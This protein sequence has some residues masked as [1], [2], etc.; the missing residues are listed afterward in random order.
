MRNEVVLSAVPKPKPASKPDQPEPEPSPKLQPKSFAFDRVFG[1]DSSQAEVF[2]QAEPIVDSVL[3]GYNG[4]IFVY[5]QTGTGKTHTM[6]GVF[7]VPELRGVCGRCF[8][9]IFET[10]GASDEDFGARPL[11]PTVLS[12]KLTAALPLSLAAVRVSYLDIYNEGIRDLLAKDRKAL[13]LKQSPEQGVYAQ[14]LSMFALKSVA[15]F[16]HVL[17]AG[18]KNR[19]VDTTKMGRTSAH[20]HSIFTIV[21]ESSATD[22]R[23]EKRVRVGKLHLV[24]LAGSEH[25]RT[26]ATIREA[27]TMGR[28]MSALRTV[29]S[30]LADR[31]QRPLPRL[32]D[33][34]RGKFIP[35]RDSKL[36]RLLQDSLGGSAKTLMIATIGPADYNYEETLSTL[37]FAT[38]AKLVHNT[39][40]VNMDPKD[41]CLRCANCLLPTQ[42]PFCA[43]PKYLSIGTQGHV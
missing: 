39:P 14:D 2:E 32:A 6:Q 5:G 38:L 18:L 4:T 15:E 20:A 7:D 8:D 29:V 36:T 3:R 34:G 26:T 23:G 24:E 22:A 27:S 10:I 1:P 21:V 41:S 28:S 31:R 17:N 25:P 9:R 30:A 12:L 13:Q 16:E 33:I 43:S 35:Y 40:R 11:P 42:V 37:R 19:M